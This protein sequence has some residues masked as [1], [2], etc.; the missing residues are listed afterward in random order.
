MNGRQR[1][2]TNAQIWGKKNDSNYDGN[3]TARH[4][5]SGTYEVSG[6]WIFVRLN[7][8]KLVVGLSIRF[9]TLQSAIDRFTMDDSGKNRRSFQSFIHIF[10]GGAQIS[11]K[12]VLFLLMH[13]NYTQINSVLA[14][15][16][17]T[18]SCCSPTSLS[19]SAL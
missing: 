19:Q 6:R 13:S 2:T 15:A 17:T 7:V 16:P 10:E 9:C 14:V 12:P 4:C 3:C 8:S 5:L 11:V 1:N 18:S